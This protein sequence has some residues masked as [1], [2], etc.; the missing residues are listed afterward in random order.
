[1]NLQM[2]FNLRS[3]NTIGTT[4]FVLVPQSRS[5]LDAL[6]QTVTQGWQTLLNNGI[7]MSIWHAELMTGKEYIGVVNLTS[8]QLAFIQQMFGAA[9]VDVQ[10]LTADQAPVLTS[11]N[12]DTAPWDGG[13]NLHD[14]NSGADCSAGFGV[15]VNGTKEL[16]TAAHCFDQG[17]TIINALGST[18]SMTTVGTVN[19]RDTAWSGTDSELIPTNASNMIQTGVIGVPA[20]S[21]VNGWATNPAGYQV[22]QSGAFSGA[23]C[24]I[25]IAS[26]TIYGDPGTCLTVSVDGYPRLE[27]HLIHANALP[28]LI[29]NQAGNSGGPVYRYIGTNLAALGIISASTAGDTVP[30]VYNSTTCYNDIYYTSIDSVLSK[31]G[32]SLNTH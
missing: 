30:C 7:T 22:C 27:C 4:N 13:D 6:N 21:Y 17:D 25:T 32:A 26:D 28:G 15:T 24:G 11:R 1:M 23:V 16:L 14:T 19:Q 20:T 29:A 31:W 12:F 9:N 10:S 18:G 2:A 3:L 5:Y 8:D